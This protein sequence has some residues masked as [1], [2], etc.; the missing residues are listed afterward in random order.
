MFS[1]S[2]KSVEGGGGKAGVGSDGL[3]LEVED[4]AVVQEFLDVKG[5]PRAVDGAVVG[6]ADFNGQVKAS[7]VVR[8]YIEEN[9]G[10]KESGGVE[11]KVDLC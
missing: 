10:R 5:D 7:V 11:E 9:G 6:E 2:L 4:G 3:S 1:N 8:M